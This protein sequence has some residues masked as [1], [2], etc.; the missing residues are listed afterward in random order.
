M[1]KK[2]II[3]CLVVKNG[4]VVQSIGFNKYLPVGKPTIAVEYL[5]RW[6]IDEIVLVDISATKNKQQPNYKMY[7]EL[8]AKCYVPLAIGG[9]IT[10]IGQVTELMHCGADKVIINK[11]ALE[12][13]DFISQTAR[14]F[15]NQCVIIAIDV[16]RDSNGK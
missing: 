7:K 6:G 8:S 2:R 9:G 12:I 11:T 16:F 4:I 15:G 10:H 14:V 3:G 13:P 5:N 1:L